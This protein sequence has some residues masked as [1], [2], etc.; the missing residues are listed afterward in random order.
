MPY[1]GALSPRQ[2]CQH[3]RIPEGKSLESGLGRA[4]VRGT[5]IVVALAIV[6]LAGTTSA[7]S[8]RSNLAAASTV[9]A[10]GA[11]Q[12]GLYV[13]LGDSIAAG[14]GAS[15]LF[16]SYVELYYGYLQSNGSGVTDLLNLSLAGAT[17]SDLRSVERLSG[18]AAI[19]ASSDTKAVT[20]DIGLNDILRDPN[21]P[22]ATAPTCPFVGNLRAILAA[23]N[24]ALATD[25][26]DETVQVLEMF[27][28]DIGTPNASATRQLL[29]GSDGKVDCSGTGAA[30]GHNDLI[31]GVSIEQGAKPIDVLP[32]FDAAGAAFLASDHLHPNDAGHLAIAKAFGGAA[33]P[34]TPPPPP[35]P[36]PPTLRASKATLSRAIAGKPLTAWMLVTNADTGK[37]VKGQV[38][39]QGKLSG[40]PLR[41]RSHSSSSSGRSSCT[42]QM[43]AAAHN[44]QFKGSITVR[45]QGADVSR[46]FS[47]KV[48]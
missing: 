44:K 40:K 8:A 11:E 20:I 33:T 46:S 22:T 18:V 35:P 21:C 26:G 41:A 30:L 17:S 42:W 28:P 15:N 3:L 1:C 10:S 37:E 7:G 23:L 45:F 32:S 48:K 6:V 16:K 38:S 13:A 36:S 24:T 2:S 34:T 19:N 12:G 43:P 31:H 4:L 25:P 9:V 27:N 5:S 29:L 47:T 39:C 14:F